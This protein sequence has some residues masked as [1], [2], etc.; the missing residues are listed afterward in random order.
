[1]KKTILYVATCFI[2]GSSIAAAPGSKVLER[3]N[4]TFPN[5]KNVK[6]NDNKKGYFVSFYQNDNFNKV[7]YN[8]AGN[9]VYSLKYSNSDALPTNIAMSVREKFEGAKIIG[10][11]EATTQTNTVYNIKLS[12]GEKIYCV[13]LSPDGTVAKQEEY[14]NGN[15]V[16]SI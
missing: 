1:M 16:D 15:T 7:F 4:E 2:I 11:T 3:F 8:K 9:F 14:I 13:D 6:W 12:K 5:A 10:V